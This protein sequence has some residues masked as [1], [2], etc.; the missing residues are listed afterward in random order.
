MEPREY[1]AGMFQFAIDNQCDIL[2]LAL[3]NTHKAWSRNDVLDWA[4]IH[5]QIG[6]IIP[7]NGR[8][9]DV[10]QLLNQVR[11]EILRMTA[12]LPNTCHETPRP[13]KHEHAAAATAAAAAE[14]KKE[15]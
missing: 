13:K 4:D 12:A 5:V 11:E 2:P 14:P 8:T 15:L 7:A 10:Q 9:T 3:N 1:K 6:Q